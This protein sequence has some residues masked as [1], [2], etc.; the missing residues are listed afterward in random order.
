MTVT[1]GRRKQEFPTLHNNFTSIDCTHWS[2][3][4]SL[5]FLALDPIGLS[6][7]TERGL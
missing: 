1:N 7:S 2:H 4:N 5:T 6:P 3:H